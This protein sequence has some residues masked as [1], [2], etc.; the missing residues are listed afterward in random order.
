MEKDQNN[1]QKQDNDGDDQNAKTEYPKC[2]HCGSDEGSWF[3]RTIPM[4]NFCVKC[5]G[6]WSE[7]D[8]VD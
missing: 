7:S 6:A 2:R 5:G 3:S 4:G 8:G 1:Q